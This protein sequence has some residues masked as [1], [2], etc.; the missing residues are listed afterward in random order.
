MTNKRQKI[1]DALVTVVKDING[2]GSFTANLFNNV[3]NKQVFLD[4]VNDYPT[5]CIWSSTESREYLPAGF[6]WA[7]LTVEIRIYVDDENAKDRLEEIFVDLET[8]LDNNNTLTIDGSNL[9][10]DLRILSL[11]DDEGLLNPLGVGEITIQIQY[12]V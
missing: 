7:F 3:K 9:C 11:T 12:E 6:K 5:V 10:T 8:V 2:Q 4:E 1:V